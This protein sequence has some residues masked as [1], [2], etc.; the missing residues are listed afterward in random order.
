[1]KLQDAHRIQVQ[2]ERTRQRTAACLEGDLAS[3][4]DLSPQLKYLHHIFNEQMK[5]HF[6]SAL[7]TCGSDKQQADATDNMSSFS[8]IHSCLP[9]VSPG[10]IYRQ[11]LQRRRRTERRGGADSDTLSLFFWFHF[12]HSPSSSC[13]LPQLLP[14]QVFLKLQMWR[15]WLCLGKQRRL[16]A[17]SKAYSF[18][19]LPPCF[20]VIRSSQCFSS[21]LSDRRP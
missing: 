1:M 2:E 13:S 8:S 21:S 10:F 4:C 20:C 19:Q 6:P 16:H 11:K 18:Y 14:E 9:S 7:V 5:L 12:L 3:G 17:L 15:I